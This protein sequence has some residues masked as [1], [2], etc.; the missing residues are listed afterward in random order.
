MNVSQNT[1]YKIIEKLRLTNSNIDTEMDAK[2]YVVR[3]K[4]I[5]ENVYEAI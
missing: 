2:I 3:K 1:I 5:K 4:P